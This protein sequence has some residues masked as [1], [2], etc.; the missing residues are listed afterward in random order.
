MITKE[1]LEKFNKEELIQLC[2]LRNDDA[3]DYS[4]TLAN[5]NLKHVTKIV[6]IALDTRN[7]KVKQLL[8]DWYN[9]DKTCSGKP[10]CVIEDCDLCVVCFDELLQKLGL[11]K[12]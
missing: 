4:K 11:D 2:L 5:N 1:K 12:K 10:H 6:E 8:Y 7:A 3:K 9:D